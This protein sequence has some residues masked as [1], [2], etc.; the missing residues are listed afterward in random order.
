MTALHA[1][2]TTLP[3]GRTRDLWAVDGRWVPGPVPG[4][5]TVIDGGFGL[6][7]LVDLHGHLSHPH[8]PRDP[9]T[10]RRLLD[11]RR[12]A[13]RDAGHTLVRDMG[14]PTDLALGFPT[15]GDGLPRLQLAGTCLLRETRWGF[16]DT[17]P[18]RL[19]AVA[20]A[21]IRAGARWVKI[22]EDWPE[23][24][25]NPDFDPP[26]GP[27]DPLVY[28]V[29]VLAETVRAVHEAGG[30]VAVHA[31]GRAGADASVQA[32][33][34]S[35]EHG[36][37]LRED[38]FEAMADRNIAWV[39]MLAI[40]DPML[41]IADRLGLGWQAAWIRERMAAMDGLVPAAHAAGV[42][43]LAGADWF[44]AIPI[45]GEIRRLHQAGL[46]ALDALAAG[47]WAARAW[48]GEPGLT[49]G[50]P[51]DLVVYDRDPRSDLT[52]LDHPRTVWIDGQDPAGPAGAPPSAAGR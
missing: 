32:G 2:L 11:E 29:E 18:E 15:A 30:R 52:A 19:P 51:A 50:A 49:P 47:S 17:P 45:A 35:I 40:S 12:V 6:A 13:H 41:G 46:P 21:Q 31:F 37:E 10:V 28:P 22:F 36:W 8:D 14:A 38:H 43:I 3:D 25:D 20:A 16:V 39:P 44:P 23:T 42:P 7:G 33:V 5:R 9:A 26:F 4:A 1:R 34:D 48:L 27:D 24:W